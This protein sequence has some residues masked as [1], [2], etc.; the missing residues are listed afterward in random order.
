MS[1]E[2]GQK[3]AIK[4]TQP[5]VGNL[6]GGRSHRVIYEPCMDT[7]NIVG[8]SN[9]T[10]RTTGWRFTALT[11]FEITHF[12]IYANAATAVKM[13]LWDNTT[14]TII[15][16]DTFLT[17]AALGWTE[18]ELPY[19]VKIE[20]SKEYTITANTPINEGYFYY[21]AYNNG[22]GVFSEYISFLG[23]YRIDAADTFPTTQLTPSP[24]I[25]NMAVDFRIR[26][27]EYSGV[28][29]EAAFS[30]TGQEYDYVPNGN[31]V[32]VT[33]PVVFVSEHSSM[34]NTILLELEP[35]F[36]NVVG[37]LTVI[38]DA[39]IGS[40][41]GSGGQVASFKVEFTPTELL[42]IPNPN[43][44]ENIEVTA[45]NATSELMRIYYT[46]TKSIESIEL[47]SISAFGDLIHINDL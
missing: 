19:S 38:Y 20:S 6:S 34:D 8:S 10:V 2:L 16:S 24:G 35:R 41:A 42:K 30:I 40:L 22:V 27:D 12:R 21:D 7:E 11:T 47:A 37:Q 39:A 14:K 4:F 32:N 17:N 31:L 13:H 44:E 18:H 29:N 28:G 15:I 3:I 1:K 9:L 43:S 45:I 33:Y 26:F 36:N 23:G 25:Y 46:D 5:L